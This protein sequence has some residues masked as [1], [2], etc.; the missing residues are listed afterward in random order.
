MDSFE[1]GRQFGY[2]IAP[3]ILSPLLGFFFAWAFAKIFKKKFSYLIA[4]GLT[5]WIF[6]LFVLSY[7]GVRK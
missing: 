6:T 3:F 4:F 1:Q 5:G 2:S 7:I